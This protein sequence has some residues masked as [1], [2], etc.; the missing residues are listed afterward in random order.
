MSATFDPGNR[1]ALPGGFPWAYHP[2]I[3]A[4]AIERTERQRYEHYRTF[5]NQHGLARLDIQALS[6]DLLASP[7]GRKLM[8]YQEIY[9]SWVPMALWSQWRQVFVPHTAFTAEL[10]RSSIEDF[11]AALLRTL[12]WTNPMIVFPGGIPVS[13]SPTSRGVIRA[14]VVAGFY[15]DDPLAGEVSAGIQA[16]RVCVSTGDERSTGLNLLVVSEVLS[17]DGTQVTGQHGTHLVVPL[18]QATGLVTVESLTTSGIEILRAASAERRD[19]EEYLR[20]AEELLPTAYRTALSHLLYLVS[21]NA[22]VGEPDRRLAM[23]GRPGEKRPA[24][25]RAV[26][27]P[28]GYRMGQA[29]EEWGR[30]RLRADA[31]SVPGE[32]G[33]KLRPHPRRPHMHAYRVGPGRQELEFKA[34]GLIEVNAHLI[35]P[36]GPDTALHPMRGGEFPADSATTPTQSSP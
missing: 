34:L 15:Y 32:S 12:T 13:L 2:H 1:S 6:D 30:R 17:D 3:P 25:G 21:R 27:L 9:H 33:R 36:D 20:D 24:G 16:A 26:F 31:A 11:P 35:G 14:V 4:W 22:E 7:L 8:Q 5:L 19:T 23:P 29:V 10:V 18:A 28:V